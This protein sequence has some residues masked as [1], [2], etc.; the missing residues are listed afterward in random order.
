MLLVAITSTGCTMLGKRIGEPVAVEQGELQEG[1][2]NVSQIV[3][4]L[5]P[6][7]HLSALPDGMV[8][9]YEY[10]DAKEQQ[11]GINLDFIGL[12]WF[13]FSFGRANAKHQDL[14]LIFDSDGLLRAQDFQ[15]WT[16]KLGSGLGFQLFFV[17]VPTVDTRHLNARSAQLS[18]GRAALEPLPVT[19]NTGQSLSS[20]THGIEMRGTPDSVGQRTLE[21]TPPKRRKQRAE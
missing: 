2:T 19:L 20:G 16:E 14:L 6:P 4:L 5:G 21:M 11:L 13:K 15:N 9:V 18:W 10:I 8:M 17:A 1:V 12:Q 7:T 3:A